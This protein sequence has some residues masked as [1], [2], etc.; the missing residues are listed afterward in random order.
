M[1]LPPAAKWALWPFGAAFAAVAQIRVSAYRRGIFRTKRLDGTVISVGNLTVG[2]TGKTPMVLWIAE[3]LA[4]E[5]QQAAILTR[6]YR[7]FGASGSAQTDGGGA[8][9]PDEMALLQMRLGERA[10]F[11]VGKNRYASGEALARRGARWFIL[12]DGFQHLALARDVDIVLLDSGDPF[13]GGHT[14]P[15]GRMREPRAALRR[16]DIVVI[17]R[18]NRAPALETVVRRYTTAPIHYAWPELDAVLSVPALDLKMP[19]NGTRSKVFAFCGIGNPT[20][21]FSDLVRWNFNVVGE[22]CFADHHWYSPADIVQIER[23]ARK[24]GADTLLCT[25]KDVFNLRAALSNGAP[26]TLPVWCCRIRLEL[27]NPQGF[28]DA[29]LESAKRR[30]ETRGH[31]TRRA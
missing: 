26:A 17:T 25:E 23:A 14:L 12:D 10:Q 29:V 30:Q 9:M 20:A 18:T 5:G 28:W 16:A 6:G 24:A 27:S 15:A 2:G 22:K 8:P 1:N 13:G 19:G 31:E 3:K 21:F 7:G 4:A 11:G